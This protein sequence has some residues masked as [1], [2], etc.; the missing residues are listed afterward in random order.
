MARRRFQRGS[1]YLRGKRRK[2]WV[3]RWLDDIVDGGQVRR[4]HRSAVLGTMEELP[5]RK[6]AMRALEQR[7]GEVN[8]VNYRPRIES[9]FS[10]FAVRYEKMILPQLKPSTQA[11][12]RSYLTGHLK[13]YWDKRPMREMDTESLQLFVS[14]LA[15][16][17]KTVRNIVG[18]LKAMWA[19]ARAWSYV[20]H[21]PFD[22]LSLPTR[23]QK[24][25]RY[26]TMEEAQ[27]VIAAADEPLRTIFWMAAETG[28]RAGELLGLR[29]V[30]INFERRVVEVRQ[31]IWRGM[32]QT[33]KTANA[34]R[35]VAISG[36]LC[37]HLRAL[38]SRWVDNPLGLLFFDKGRPLSWKVVVQKR[39]HPLLDA[40]KIPR[41][42]LHAFRHSHETTMDRWG[43]PL[44][45]R[46]QRLGHADPRTTLTIYT[47]AADS[48]ERA[49]VD[50]LGG[51]LCPTL[52]NSDAAPIAQQ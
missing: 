36:E 9:T 37:D 41:G 27:K 47:H 2:V 6:L 51:I 23:V 49:F 19:Y 7:L 44:K 34:V 4:V 18:V 15:K 45:V 35:C 16:D 22:G 48:D 11:G 10:D 25:Q 12:Y 13:P 33:P 14:G 8:S 20:S 39:L 32:V 3:G 24:E 5:T 31:S 30:D 17:P 29:V 28:L 38:I 46:Q 50:R 26:F 40:L 52:P 42:G 1:L 43:V 21:N